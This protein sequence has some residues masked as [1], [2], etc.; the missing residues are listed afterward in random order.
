MSAKAKSSSFSATSREAWI[1]S[2][3]SK[4]N[5]PDVGKYK[6]KFN[7]VEKKEL[8]T[9]IIAPQKNMG[10]ERILNRELQHTHFCDKVLHVIN[11]KKHPGKRI[12]QNGSQIE[13]GEDKE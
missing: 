13:E 8:Y 1:K 11:D 4:T 6:P 9:A 5:P 12:K 10:Q 2:H 7:Q 3:A